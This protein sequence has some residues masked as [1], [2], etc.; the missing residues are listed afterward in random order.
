MKYRIE[1]PLTKECFLRCRY[2]FHSDYFNNRGIYENSKRYPLGFSLEEFERWRNKFLKNASEILVSFHSGETFTNDNTQLMEDFILFNLNSIQI[3]E[4]LSNG[5]SPIENYYKILQQYKSKIRR[6]G[7]TYHRTVLS[8][9]QKEQFEET[10][11]EVQKIG[12]P[13]Y[14][15]ELLITEYREEIKQNIRYW[16]EKGIEVKVQDFKGYNKGK[17]YTEYAKYTADDLNLIDPEYRHPLNKFCECLEGYKNVLIFGY[18]NYSNGGN[19]TGC[20]NDQKIVGN[21]KEMWFNPNYSVTRKKGKRCIVGVPEI[22]LGNE[23]DNNCH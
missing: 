3:Y 6:I 9:K 4:F 10:I 1:M 8:D 17:D 11:L 20:W 15:K 21:I 13:L 5:L 19:I 7:F 14:I 2:C 18:D 23:N 22:Y 12:V 16:K